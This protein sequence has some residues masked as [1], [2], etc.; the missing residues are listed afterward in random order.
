MSTHLQYPFTLTVNEVSMHT[1][2][3]CTKNRYV[4][5]CI[6]CRF[7]TA[8][9]SKLQGRTDGG[10]SVYIPPKTILPTNFYVVTGLFFLFDPGQ[11]RYRASVRLSSCFFYLLT[12]HNL[13][14]PN[15]IPG[16]A[17]GKLT[18]W[19]CSALYCIA[20]F[21]GIESRRVNFFSILYLFVFCTQICVLFRNIF[22]YSEKH[23]GDV[24][25]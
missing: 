17:P 7:I 11:I 18:D 19:R 21:S 16:Y 25:L 13:Y 12:H 10:I 24:A 8:V 5:I 4:N 22:T 2:G 1:A 20:A 9:F 15:E 14:P 3:W 23:Q 6:L